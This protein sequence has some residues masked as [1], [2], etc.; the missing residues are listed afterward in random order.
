MSAAGHG[1]AARLL[2]RTLARVALHDPPPPRAALGGQRDTSSSTGHLLGGARWARSRLSPGRNLQHREGKRN[3]K[4]PCMDPPLLILLLI[5][6]PGA[7][8]AAL[9]GPIT[10][11]SPQPSQCSALQRGRDGEWRRWGA[12]RARDPRGAP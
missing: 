12:H 7:T 2:T 9:T 8:F 11:E 10:A 3:G 1:L 5:P 4:G 6:S